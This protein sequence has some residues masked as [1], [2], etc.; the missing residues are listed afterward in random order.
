M[1]KLE[2]EIEEIVDILKKSKKSRLAACIEENWQKTALDYSKELNTWA[3]TRPM[4][5]ELVSAFNKELER[6]GII[7]TLKT[8]ILD[9]L[10]KRRILQ[11]AP[12]LVATENPR[13]LCINWLGSLGVPED[14]FY[15]VGMFSGIPF[16]NN[17]R[18]G[19]I[20]RKDESVNLFPSSMQ[21]DLVYGSKIPEKLVDTIKTLSK[22]TAEIKKLLP[23]AKVGD[24]Y[25]K[26][27]LS[28]CANIER[29]IIKK[30][31]LIY[32]D[33]NEVV[34]NYLVEIKGKK[35]H[36][37]YNIEEFKNAFR[38]ETM[39]YKDNSSCPGLFLTFLSLAFLNEFKC[40][41]SFRQVEYLPEYQRKLAQL[42]FMKEYRV[43]KVPTA[44]LTTGEFLD[45]LFPVDI[46]LGKEFRPDHNMLFGE[47][48]TN[49]M[50]KEWLEKYTS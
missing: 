47:L 39:F 3:P 42:P 12:H 45:K 43:E 31:N 22:E 35:N 2:K 44:S 29:K 13:M 37:L 34:S 46:I 18:P 10:E 41:G 50:T 26:W 4:E 9:S 16:S 28:T 6:L 1:V 23:K 27:A 15:V 17:Y 14:E 19:R 11:T 25:T 48:I 49:M 8:K 7:D 20:N 5:P 32:I 24:S 40:F 33:I 21:D 30:E 38:E 36:P